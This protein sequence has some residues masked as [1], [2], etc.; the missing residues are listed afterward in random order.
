MNAFID[1]MRVHMGR[2]GLHVFFF[3]ALSCSATVEPSDSLL[4]FS[5]LGPYILEILSIITSVAISTLYA[6]SV[7]FYALSFTSALSFISSEF[8]VTSHAFSFTSIL[9]SPVLLLH[10]LCFSFTLH[11]SMLSLDSTN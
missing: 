5:I 6:F 11:S 7:T 2:P 8:Y 4:A 3:R 9:S 10:V 1:V